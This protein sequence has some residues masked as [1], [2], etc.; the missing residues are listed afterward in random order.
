MLWSS[1][2]TGGTRPQAERK[3]SRGVQQRSPGSGLVDR[4]VF[5]AGLPDGD[6]LFFDPKPPTMALSRS[7]KALQITE[8]KDKMS[9]A[10]SVIFTQYLGLTVADITKLRSALRKEHAEMQVAKKSLIQLAAKEA[11]AP[12]IT[13]EMLPG[14]IACIFSMKEP[15]AGANVAYIFGKTH[16]PIKLIGGIFSGKI[17]SQTEANDL[18]TIP[19]KQILLA[20]FASMCMSPLVSFAS[21]CSSPLTGFARLLSEIAKNKAAETPASAEA[22]V[23]AT[24]ETA[25]PAAAP[26]V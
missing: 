9:K 13:D 6:Q 25:A 19:S 5:L 22:V 15:T 1:P 26:T 12:E 16:P 3:P 18:A 23:A 14:G 24:P 10:S 7:Q 2:K 4:A 11:K 21:A 20:T 17:L 8:L